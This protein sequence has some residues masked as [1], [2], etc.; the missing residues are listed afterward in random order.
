MYA[1]YKIPAGKKKRRTDEL[2]FG[3][4]ELRFDDATGTSRCGLWFANF[5]QHTDEAGCPQSLSEIYSLA[6]MAAVAIPLRY[7]LKDA[8]DPNATKNCVITNLWRERTRE[9]LYNIPCLD[10]SLY[11]QDNNNT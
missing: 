2:R 6:K 3:W 10:F 7:A 1:V 8:N 4:M 11:H 5:E 9:G